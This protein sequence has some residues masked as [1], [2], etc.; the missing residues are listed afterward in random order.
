[1]PDDPNLNYVTVM[2]GPL[3]A[4]RRCHAKPGEV[5][6]KTWNR[7][8]HSVDVE[9]AVSKSRVDDP[10]DHAGSCMRSGPDVTDEFSYPPVAGAL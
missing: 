2:H 3:C 10:A 4:D 1:M 9:W 5:L 6:I 8:K 7:G